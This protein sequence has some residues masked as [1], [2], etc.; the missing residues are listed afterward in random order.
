M[1]MVKGV[2]SSPPVTAAIL[3]ST[4]AYV[5][6]LTAVVKDA[7]WEPRAF[8][9]FRRLVHSVEASGAQ[10]VFINSYDMPDDEEALTLVRRA[11]VGPLVVLVEQEEELKGPLRHGATLAVKKPF[12]PEY[13]S[14]AVSAVLARDEP[15]NRALTQGAILGDLQVRLADHTIERRGRRQALG[16]AEWQLFAFLMAHPRRILDRHEL[17]R[18]AW[19]MDLPG[20]DAE[21]EL[22]VS[23]LRHKIELN[24]RH[25]DLILTVRGRG[26]QLDVIPEPLTSLGGGTDGHTALPL[27]TMLSYWQG[28]YEEI[29]RVQTRILDRTRGM[30]DGTAKAIQG[31]L[32]GNDL[33]SLQA[34]MER[35][36]SRLAFW[37]AWA[38]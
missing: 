19:G 33:P 35:C 27:T 2:A 11:F 18:G 12:D 4:P 25:P 9:T 3:E 20:R 22:Y 14:L 6:M 8:A 29:V 34:E 17:A 10:L 23:R 15:L 37:N 16:P 7:G 31:Q 21:V 1:G 24:P 5:A 30:A 38:S 28:A 36:E 26:Y 32:L 13:L